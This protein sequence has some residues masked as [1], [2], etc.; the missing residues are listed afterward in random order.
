MIFITGDSESPEDAYNKYVAD[1]L[2]GETSLRVSASDFI[3]MRDLF[4]FSGIPHDREGK[5]IEN[6]FS[7]HSLRERLAKLGVTLK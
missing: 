5:V 1:N 4:C 6:G 3:R 7:Y 2:A